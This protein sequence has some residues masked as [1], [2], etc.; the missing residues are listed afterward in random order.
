MGADFDRFMKDLQQR[1]IEEARAV[2]SD[3]VVREF[4]NPKNVGRLS[5]PEAHAT[6]K[7]WCGDTMEISLRLSGEKI[8]EAGFMTDGC[9]PTVACGS[10]LTTMVQNMSLKEARRIRPQ[11]LIDALDGLPEESTHCADL[12]VKT[13]HKAISDLL[14]AAGPPLELL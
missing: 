2:Y 13:L 14:R 4:S 7:G 10:M 8:E 12:A 6:V 9:G 1:M 11:Q 5:K 3:T